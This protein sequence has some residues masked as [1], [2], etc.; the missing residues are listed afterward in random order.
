MDFKKRTGLLLAGTVLGASI[1][2]SAPAFADDAQLQN[3]ITV[4]QQQLQTMQ[5]QLAETKKQAKA[6]ATKADELQQAQN[7]IPANLYNA[8]M[9]VPTKSAPSWFDSIH[10]SMAGSFIAMEGA[11]RQRS[12]LASGASDT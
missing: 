7:S 8:D 10:V 1:L 9:P 11:F 5:N 6:A 12:E 3:Q 2:I 4:M